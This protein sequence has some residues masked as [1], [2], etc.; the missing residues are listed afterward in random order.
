MNAKTAAERKADERARKRQSGL[1]EVRGIW[2]TK[3]E[4]EKL[5]ALG[6]DWLR[7]RIKRAKPVDI[8][9]SGN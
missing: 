5:A 9:T 1:E 2:L 7:E 3:A 8:P 4:R 6:V